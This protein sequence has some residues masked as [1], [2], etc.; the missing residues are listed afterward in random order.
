MA[1]QKNT[2]AVVTE[3]I[4]P[5]VEQLGFVLWDVEFVKEGASRY[6]RITIDSEDGVDIEGCEAVHRAIDP[7]LDEADP[8]DVSYYLEV[9]SPGIERTLRT[10]EHFE[11]A[12]GLEIS[13]KLYTAVEGRKAVS[14]ILATYADDTLTIECAE[15]NAVGT[16]NVKRSDIAKANLVFDFNGAR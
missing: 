3:L 15:G 4:T 2:A 6:L 1:S 14:G 8:I 13:V 16:V 7:I 11:W 10:P 5:T 12:V 9:S